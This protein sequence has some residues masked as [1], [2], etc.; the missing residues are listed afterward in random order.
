[1]SSVKNKVRLQDYRHDSI[2]K[3][4]SLMRDENN[5]LVS[6]IVPAFNEKKHI[7]ECLISIRNQS[8]SNIE[9]IVV[10]DGSTDSTI[11]I[12]KKYADKLLTQ[13][14]QG[15]GAAKNRGAK[16]A[17][18]DILV[19]I[20]SDMFLD[21]NFVRNIIKPIV[22]GKA[23]ATFNN[24][25]YVANPDN[26]WS[27]CFI[28]DN[29][30]KNNLRVKKE[31]KTST[32]FRAI[33]KKIFMDRGGY[34]ARLGYVDDHFFMQEEK[35]KAIVVENAI[36]YHY[37]SD[38]LREV[39]YSARW[40]GR[41][42]NISMTIENILKYSIFNSIYI[43]LKKIFRGAPLQFIIY[44]LVFDLGIESGILNKNS[45]ANFSK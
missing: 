25:E 14:H 8:C 13:K 36:C 11:N 18:G 44:K 2:L 26:V 31:S 43:S 15:P 6:V 40:I 35:T 5:Q 27:K 21:E 1:M 12:S 39:F 33:R 24:Q 38:S 16:V 4:K 23:I 34:N 10:D 19:F 9:L 20:D 37:N 29:N 22:S 45:Q 32:A 42:T 7:K 17:R 30:L 3:A 41:S 28:V